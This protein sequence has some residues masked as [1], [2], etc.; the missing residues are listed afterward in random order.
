MGVLD[1]IGRQDV[2]AAAALRR[3]TRGRPELY[4]RAYGFISG[5]HAGPV[6]KLVLRLRKPSRLPAGFLHLDGVPAVAWLTQPLS[7]RLLVGWA[8]G[9]AAVR[10]ARRPVEPVIRAFAQRAGVASLLEA[11]WRFDWTDD[12]WSGGAYAYPLAGH[13]QAPRILGEPVAGT[14]YFAGEATAEGGGA[15]TVH[16]ALESGERAAREILS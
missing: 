14:L 13:A 7:D 2:P 1:E 3:A 6:V 5:F 4:R 10:L 11:A 16:G 9:P 15:A 8:G 12:R